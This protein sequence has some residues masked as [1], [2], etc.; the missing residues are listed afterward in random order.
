MKK[1][2]II[3]TVL[4]S[5]L[6]FSSCGTQSGKHAEVVT[7]TPEIEATDAEPSALSATSETA[8]SSSPVNTSRVINNCGNCAIQ[9]EKLYYTNGYDNGTLYSINVNGSDNLKLNNDW[10]PWFYVSGDRIYYQ[11]GKDGMNIYVMNTDGSG[12][13]KLNDDNSGNINIVGD[14]IYYSNTD[15]G[16]TLYSMNTD[17]SDRKKLNGDN[18]LYMNVAGDRIYYSGE[19]S[20]IKGIYSVKTDGTDRIKLTDDS[21]YLMLVADGWIYYNNENDDSKLYA[22][23][24]DG[25]S[26]HKLNDD[27]ALSINVVDDR[28]YYKNGNDGKIYSINTDGG[29]R[30]LLSDDSADWL[31]VQDSRIYYTITGSMIYSMNIDGSDKQLLTDLTSDVY[32]DVTYEINARLHEDMPEYRFVATG[33]TQTTD[34]WASGYVMGLEVYD[35]NGL[36]ILSADFSQTVLDQVVGNAVYNQMMDTMGLHVADVNFDGYKDVII[37]NNFSGAHGNTWYD[38]WLWNPE[39]SSFVKSESFADICNPALDPKK[40][41]IYSTGGSGASNQEWDIYQFIDGEFVVTNSLSY[42]ETNEGR[43][44]FIE[45]K[46][47]NGK[48]KIIRDDVIQADSFD[49][50]LSAAGYINDELWQLNNS[51]WYGLGGHQADQWLE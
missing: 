12:Q 10:T 46:L 8:Q 32:K 28:I 6:S 20:G 9:G 2:V 42:T 31:V 3:F 44:H 4:L 33:M 22:I 43:Y 41:C 51:R 18:P 15:D 19:L 13:Q 36:P 45:Q 40:K 50:A 29:D 34:D 47:V 37:L 24:T 30:K 49:D 38:C 7:N 39:T 16:F 25:S 11:N 14:R 21:P 26:R 48:M 5:I 1:S 23:R 17:G 35:E 27:Y